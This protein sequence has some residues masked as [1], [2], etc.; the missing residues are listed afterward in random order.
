MKELFRHIPIET[1]TRVPIRPLGQFSDFVVMNLPASLTAIREGTA[2]PSALNKLSEGLIEGLTSDIITRAISTSAS[3]DLALLDMLIMDNALVRTTEP[4]PKLTALIDSFSAANGRPPVITYEDLI[5]INPLNTDCRTNTEVEVGSTERD[6]YI[7]HREIEEDLDVLIDTSKDAIERL[8]R[9]G[10]NAVIDVATMIHSAELK[11]VEINAYMN[12]LG[13]TM[14]TEHFSTF[15]PYFLE[16]PA[17]TRPDGRKY[18]GPSGA[19]T[20]SIPV[21]EIL[22]AGEKM[23]QEQFNYFKDNEIYFPRKG[24]RDIQEALE[25]LG[26]GFT[27]TQLARSLDNPPILVEELAKLDYY[28]NQFRGK[29][30]AGVRRQIPGAIEGNVSGSAGEND[31]GKFLKGRMIR[32]VDK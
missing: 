18:K 3:A 23:N 19:F 26:N 27:L 16:H 24:K 20:A 10:S 21:F 12:L 22:F 6:F 4:N 2:N 15:R 11:W 17:R 13:E 28:L 32:H 1:I 7:A 9:E 25:Y 5:L 31:V 29:H 14:S 30:Y 8:K